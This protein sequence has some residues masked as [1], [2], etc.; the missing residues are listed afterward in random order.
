MSKLI[1]IFIRVQKHLTRDEAV[2]WVKATLERS[3][4][5]ELPGTLPAYASFSAVLGTVST[6][7]SKLLLRTSTKSHV[8]AKLFVHDRCRREAA[9]QEFVQRLIAFNV[10]CRPGE[11]L[12]RRTRGSCGEILKDKARPPNDVQ[13]LIHD[14]SPEESRQAK[15]RKLTQRAAKE[16]S[17]ESRT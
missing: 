12:G 4:G 2:R 14:D 15:Y 7:G 1:S 13:S 10:D 11:V 9:S 8:P 16:S 5:H 17:E 3:R 6:M